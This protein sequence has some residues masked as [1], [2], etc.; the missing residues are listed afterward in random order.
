LTFKTTVHIDLSRSALY[1]LR[2]LKAAI[3]HAQRGGKGLLNGAQ[4]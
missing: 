3:A 1:P 2:Q 4:R